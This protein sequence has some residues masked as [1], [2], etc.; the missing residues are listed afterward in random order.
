M[1][2]EGTDPSGVPAPPPEKTLPYPARRRSVTVERSSSV[3]GRKRA[4][5]YWSM[6]PGVSESSKLVIMW[7][8]GGGF[9]FGNLYHPQFNVVRAGVNYRLNW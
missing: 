3:W 8:G 7:N 1:R 2:G 9:D 6:K 4:A 5:M